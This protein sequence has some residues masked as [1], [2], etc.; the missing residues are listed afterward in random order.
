MTGQRVAIVLLVLLAIVF[1]AGV[2]LG[3]GRD[4]PA[5]QPGWA[6][7]LDG[8][9]GS[10]E[11]VRPGEVRGPCVDGASLVVRPGAPCTAEIRETRRARVRYLTLAL[12]DGSKARVEIAPKDDVA[13][14]MSVRLRADVSKPPKLPILE[15]GASMILKCEG[16]NPM[17]QLCRVVVR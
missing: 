2:G 1:A 5:G 16:G 6:T 7:T 11:T 13:A 15:K 12:A 4:G 14:P 3:V 17:T 9:F 10:E 8:W